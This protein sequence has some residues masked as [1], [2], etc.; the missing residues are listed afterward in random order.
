MEGV[1]IESA[2]YG[3]LNRFAFFEFV[4]VH[5]TPGVG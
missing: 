4:L 2:V 3:Q 1:Q 5:V